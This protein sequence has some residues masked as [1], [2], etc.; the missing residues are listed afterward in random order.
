AAA[1]PAVP[2][3]AKLGTWGVDLSGRD[4]KVKPG[5]DFERYASGTWL[6]KTEIAADKPEV[7]SFYDLFDRSQDQLKALITNA[8]ADSK[9]GALYKSMM[10]EA[11]VEAVGLA[12]LKRDLAA[13]AAIKTKAA[14]ARHMGVTDGQFGS[15]LFGFYLQPDTADAS[16]N[17]LNLV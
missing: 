5:D 12:P 6:A 4:L 10:D 13:V 3:H 11:R 1:T 7:S 15:S 9:Y 17:A 2:A 16:M 14:M 8:P